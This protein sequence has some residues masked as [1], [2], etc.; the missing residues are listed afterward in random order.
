MK[1]L[2]EDLGTPLF[3]KHGRALKL[4]EAGHTALGYARRMLALNDDLLQTM[5]ARLCCLTP[6]GSS[7][8]SIRECS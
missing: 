4:T 7:R 2:Q 5:Q 8:R 6:C 1:R 3:H